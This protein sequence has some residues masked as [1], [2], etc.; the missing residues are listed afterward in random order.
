MQNS[1]ERLPDMTAPRDRAGATRR[2]LSANRL[3]PLL[4]RS[5][6]ALWWEQLWP[7]VLAPALVVALFLT[8]SWF[9]L[10]MHVHGLVQGALLALFAALF[11]ASLWP[12][13]RL[14]AVR[15]K[16]LLAR[17][18]AASQLAHQPLQALV[19]TRVPHKGGPSEPAAQV[20]WAAHQ[21]WARDAIAGIKPAHPSPRLDK[22][23]SHAIR[24]AIALVAIVAFFRAPA[25]RIERIAAAFSFAPARPVI[26]ARIDAWVSPPAYTGR[27]PVVLSK[28]QLAAANSADAASGAATENAAAA[29]LR[30][31]SVTQ[32]AT[33]TVRIGAGGDFSVVTGALSTALHDKAGGGRV[34]AP[35]DEAQGKPDAPRDYQLVLK[36]SQTVRIE[37]AA[38]FVAGWAFQVV[39]DQAPRIRL[40]KEPQT[41]QSGSLRLTYALEDDHGVI[42]AE[43]RFTATHPPEGAPGAV[44]PLYEAPSFRLSLPRARTR[45]AEASTFR[46]LL[47]H[48]WAGAEVDMILAAR[49]DA[50]NEGVSETRRITLPQR[51][52]FDPL[53]RALVEQRRRLALDANQQTRVAYALDAITFAPQEHMDDFGVYLG[54]RVAHKRLGA[55]DDD[56]ALREVADMLWQIALSIEDGDLSRQEQ[57]LRRAREELR[58]AL[59]NDAGKEEIERLVKQL[60]QAM[61]DYMQALAQQQLQRPDRL[62]SGPLD[63]N[64]RIVR[65]QDLE[66]MLDRLEDLSQLGARDAAREL[67][68]QLDEMMENMRQARRAA[69]GAQGEINEAL[70]ELSEIIRRQQQLL[71]ENNRQMRRGRDGPEGERARGRREGSRQGRGPQDD[72]GANRDGRSQE[73]AG[74][75]G[76]SGQGGRA[77][78]GAEQQAL[79]DRL[80]ELMDRL[81]ELGMADQDGYR[82]FG[83]AYDEMGEAV[84]QFTRDNRDQAA[85]D[86]AAALEALRQGAQAALEQLRQN[87]MLQGRIGG[88]AQTDPFGRPRR[89]T[90]PDFGDTVEIPD[91]IDVQRARRI[92]RELRRRLGETERGIVE[93]EYIERLLERF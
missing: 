14:R 6:L 30:V 15:R 24:F 25:E 92:L 61:R 76:R 81:Q 86:Q 13:T 46:N 18:E 93:R 23:D 75:E 53:A 5:Y 8:A 7:C 62:Q 83:R 21:Q 90:G 50:D 17:M 11:V 19:D 78:I 71:D 9:G 38:G 42:R 87:G 54:L 27:P 73:R 32:N 77:G 37:S 29:T 28:H 88:P 39:P 59:E 89:T 60:R 1:F 91:D 69:Q 47:A 4:G 12:L 22:Y 85:Q 43:A 51:R 31:I 58:Q 44:R 36:D 55:A 52:F 63:P 48:P 2:S 65:P 67:L 84:D 66:R 16:Q 79:R 74:D 64:T 72:Q 82:E 68:S 40:T 3:V 20:L 57:A 56:D 33:L 10:W 41:A 70:G 80:N 45:R 35:L 34:V 49:D 26:A